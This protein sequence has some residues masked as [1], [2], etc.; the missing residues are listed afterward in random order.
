MRP[1]SFAQFRR[2]LT[3]EGA[4][5]RGGQEVTPGLCSCYAAAVAK[6]PS[7]AIAGPGR[8]GSA[9]ARALANAGYDVREVVSRGSSQMKSELARALKARATKTTTARLDSDLI[10]FCVPDREIA[11]AARALASSTEWKGKIALHSSGAL[12]SDELNV[13]R[14]RGAAVASVHPMMTFVHGSAPSLKGV[15]FAAEG[16]RRAVQAAR[17]VVSRLGGELMLI[18]KKH[19]AAYHAWGTLLSPLL[20]SLLVTAEEVARAAGMPRERARRSAPPIVRQTIS[21]YVKLGPE[22]AFSGPLV[23]GDAAIVRRHL[24]MLAK[25]PEAKQVYAALAKAALRYLPAENERELRSA[26]SRWS[27]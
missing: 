25:I 3:A 4:E 13:L 18:A 14:Q 23:R 8:L 21:N 15:L 26:L 1:S 27:P 17:G 16:D 7:I 19:K 12:T 9:L 24:L 20:L 2:S 10:W 5:N 11:R 6:K 22:R